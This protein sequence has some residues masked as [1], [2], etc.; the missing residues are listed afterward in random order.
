ML[1]SY[2]KLLN[3][4]VPLGVLMKSEQRGKD[5]VDILQHIHQYIPKHP[6]GECYPLSFG[7]DQLTKQRVA[8]A[9]NAKLQSEKESRRLRGI[10]PVVEDW[11]ARMIFYQVNYC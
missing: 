8:G 5:M 3:F 2:N 10:M 9:Q 11:H 4:Q 6:T 1:V 7:G